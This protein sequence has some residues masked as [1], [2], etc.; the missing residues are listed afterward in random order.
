MNIISNARGMSRKAKAAA[1]AALVGGLLVGSLGIAGA[2]NAAEDGEVG[3][4]ASETGVTDPTDHYYGEQKIDSISVTKNSDGT[5]SIV[6]YSDGT[7]IAETRGPAGHDGTTPTPQK[8]E[9]T[10]NATE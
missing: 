2:A 7:A 4:S 6:Y 9:G 5:D 3:S 8:G 1:G 10:P